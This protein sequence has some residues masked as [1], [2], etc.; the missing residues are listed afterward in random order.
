MIGAFFLLVAVVFALFG[1][2]IATLGN[3]HCCSVCHRPLLRVCPEG[4]CGDSA[5]AQPPTTAALLLEES[6]R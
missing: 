6:V 5:K 2:L 3:R 1:Y 4:R